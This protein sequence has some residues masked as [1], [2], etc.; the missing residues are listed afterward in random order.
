MQD[1]QP[2]RYPC[3]TMPDSKNVSAELMIRMDLSLQGHPQLRHFSVLPEPEFL[4]EQELRER[5]A[6]SENKALAEKQK[7][8]MAQLD[9]TR[10]DR[11]QAINELLTDRFSKNHGLQPE[12]QILTA[13]LRGSPDYAWTWV[14]NLAASFMA[15]GAD[16]ASANRA[17][18]RFLHALTQVNVTQLPHFQQTQSHE[19]YVFEEIVRVAHN[20]DDVYAAYMAYYAMLTTQ[21]G[22]AMIPS[23]FPDVDQ[24][25]VEYPLAFRFGAHPEGNR[26][27]ISY[28]ASGEKVAKTLTEQPAEAPPATA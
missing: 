17:A 8:P 4:T 20:R 28:V 21:R 19:G 26:I 1:Q 22:Q 15:E 25:R 3:F 23:G 5:Q 2:K 7:L 11:E 27:V 16:H 6:E 18:A 9:L 14:C 24:N 10:E 12:M 13:A